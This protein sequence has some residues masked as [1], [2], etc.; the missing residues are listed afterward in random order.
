MNKTHLAEIIES[1][2]PVLVIYQPGMDLE[3]LNQ[4]QTLSGLSLE[5]GGL[6]GNSE[7]FFKEIAEFNPEDEL[8]SIASPDDHG[9]IFYTSGTVDRPKGVIQTTRPLIIIMIRRLIIWALNLASAPS[10]AGR[11]VGCQ[12]NI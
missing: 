12:L 7:G 9:V 6:N 8:E 4:A 1:I 5:N 11:I 2:N 3:F 10:I